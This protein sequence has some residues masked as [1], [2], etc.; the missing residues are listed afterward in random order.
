LAFLLL[1]NI[2]IV[3]VSANPIETTINCTIHGQKQVGPGP[4]AGIELYQLKN[5]ALNRVEWKRFDENGHCSFNVDVKKEGI[6][7]IQKVSK[8][9]D[10]KYVLYL[11]AGEQKT[12]DLYL[13][14]TSSDYDSVKI[15]K[16]NAETKILQAWLNGFKNYSKIVHGKKQAETYK[17]YEEFV[18]FSS[19]FL[20]S[21]KT[22]NSYFNAWLADK[23]DTD[24]KY[25]RAA[26]FFRFN[27]RFLAGYDSS[28]VVQA[29]YQPLENKKIINDPRLLRSEHGMD[30]LRYVLAYWKFNQ[31][32]NVEDLTA[33]NL[34]ASIYSE[35]FPKITNNN[36]KVSYIIHKMNGETAIKKYEEFRKYVQPYQDLFNTAEWKAVYQKMYDEL[37]LF[38]KGTPGYNFE[39]KD[40]NEKTYTLASF[41]GKV[42][43]VDVWAMWCAP[44]LE[45][46]PV[47]EKIAEGY[48]DR[49]DIVFVGISCDGFGKKEPWKAFVKR[50]GY[51]SIE[52]LSDPGG[53]VK[54]YYKMDGI[55]PFPGF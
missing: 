8:L 50:H 27:K 42:V 33:Y 19:S 16:P 41:K 52:L 21:N 37:Y 1:C 47:M 4:A 26:N 53:S 3:G 5:G 44:C 12:L 51:T 36:I 43:I 46:K 54:A 11:K 23:V 29:F 48:K 30:F 2:S 14:P 15:D 45:E 28:R 38:A 31:V 10:V 6:Y 13:Q 34:Q 55:P 9:P 18:T 40:G 35:D 20:K 7:F 39:L 24:L 25:L 17:L 49:N 32:K 22:T